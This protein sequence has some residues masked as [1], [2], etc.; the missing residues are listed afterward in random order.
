L[1][2]DCAKTR[3]FSIIE[4]PQP[5][6]ERRRPAG[7]SLVGS[8]LAGSTPAFPGSGSARKLILKILSPLSPVKKFFPPAAAFPVCI[9]SHF[10]ES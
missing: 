2:S 6:W 9:S 3:A 1:D 4:L 7:K 10:P 5:S 8:N